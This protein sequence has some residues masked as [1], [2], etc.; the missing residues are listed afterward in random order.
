MVI[1]FFAFWHSSSKKHSEIKLSSTGLSPHLS[2]V[3]PVCFFPL[4]MTYGE[5]LLV[6]AM[7][8]VP[9]ELRFPPSLTGRN[10]PS[11]TGTC[12]CSKVCGWVGAPHSLEQGIAQCCSTL[13]VDA[14]SCVLGEQWDTFQGLD[15]I[16][17]CS[18]AWSK[19][20]AIVLFLGHAGVKITSA[21]NGL[22]LSL[23]WDF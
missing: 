7:L 20:W 8:Y 1:F 23:A 3:Y 11:V 14:P 10:V 4:T 9:C 21:K 17:L 12:F 2:F 22:F 13:P 16:G 19:T 15:L 5:Q 6:E 18:V